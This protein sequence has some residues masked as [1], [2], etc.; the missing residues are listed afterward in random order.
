MTQAT[1]PLSTDITPVSLEEEMRR[2][3]LDYAMSVIVSRALPDVR[4]GLKPVHR[5]ILYA[6]KESGNNPDRPYRKSASAVGYVMMKYH[7]HG[8]API[9]EALARLAQDFSMRLPLIDGQGNFGSM[10][11]DPPAAERYTEARL[12]K[13]SQF[14]LEDI[15]KETVDFKPNY[16]GSTT[17]P[18]VLPSRFPNL[19]VNGA[20]GI[21]VGMATNIPPHNLGEVIDAC[22]A[23]IDNPDITVDELLHYVPGPDFP[24]GAVILGRTGIREAAHSGRGSIIMRGRV[25]IEEIRKDRTAIIITEVPYQV[26]KARMIERMAEVVKE[27]IIE[28]ISDLRDES[29]RE[30]VRVVVELKRDAVPDVVL[31]QLYRHTPLQTSFG[32]NALA[33]DKG[34]PRQMGLKD[35]IKAFIEFREDVIVR[36]IKFDLKKARERAH[37]LIGLAIAVANIDEMIALIKN[38]ADPQ[39]AR[40]QM[41]N[42]TWPATT[43]ASL[44]ELVAEPGNTFNNGTY[45]LSEAQARAILDLRLHRLTGLE[46]DKIADELQQIVDQIKEYLITLAS[47]DKLY[48]LM[49]QELTEVKEQ[50]ATPRRTTIEEAVGEFDI[51]DLI[52][53]EDMV[54]TVSQNGYIK[55]VPLSTYRAQKRGGRGRS[56]MSTREEDFVRDVVVADTHTPVLFFSSGGKAF[57]LKVYQLPQGTPQSLGKPIINVLPFEQGETIATVLPLPKD[58]E[59]LKNMSIV[60]ATSSGTVRRNSIDDF[61]NVR[62]NGKIAMK[63]EDGEQLI[64]VRACHNHQ[65]LLLSSKEGRSVRFPV[66]SLRV[67]AS[68]SST[69]VLGIRLAAGDRV[70]SMS[71]LD[72]ARATIEERD[73]YIRQSRKLRGGDESEA[74]EM[75]EMS[76]GSTFELSPERF[77]ELEASEQFILS[78]TEN[79]MGK[80]TSAYEFR[81]TNRGA[82]GVTNT[83]LTSKTG[84]IVASFV[85]ESEDQLV[86]VTNSG[87]LIRLPVKDIRICGRQ[88]QGVMLFRVDNKEQV[89][90]V[91][92]IPNQGNEE[93]EDENVLGNEESENVELTSS[94]P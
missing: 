36:R 63:L 31:N 12:A 38:A 16:D 65:D 37:L 4:D 81:V 91:A 94:N 71:I 47:R 79:G 88:A 33:L 57:T 24:T 52:Q 11:G 15:E 48:A 46:R 29:D 45:R 17:E 74:E 43:V 5:R 82:Q 3:Y 8:N 55:R 89:V 69:G 80:R 84:K 18:S 26:N 10:D 76:E 93:E 2:S 73:A 42:R 53:C 34:Q 44:I 1:S 87:Q 39:T 28:G 14:L 54:V 51:E 40:E 20:G 7:P 6:M 83:K 62:A 86:L 61:L 68:R 75:E 60:F 9:Y 49:R 25:Q 30:G 35:V 59:E 21:A 72:N 92:R 50:F 19:L 90:S 70:I 41:M 22:F 77:K 85:V 58:P 66:E 78:V 23:Y 27:K 56:G 64:A 67:F 32:V 13:V